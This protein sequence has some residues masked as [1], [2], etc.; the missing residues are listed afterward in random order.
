MPD[1]KI[2]HL[3]E[4]MKNIRKLKIPDVKDWKVKHDR[5]LDFL[6]IGPGKP[7]E[8]PC[9]VSLSVPLTFVIDQEGNI[10][11]LMFEYAEHEFKRL[12]P[13]GINPAW[14]DKPCSSLDDDKKK[15][16]RKKP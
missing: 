5:D 13:N 7:W 11:G 9:N 8:G 6:Y 16:R 12:F 14:W 1:R 10:N 3:D 4:A 2:H 15:R